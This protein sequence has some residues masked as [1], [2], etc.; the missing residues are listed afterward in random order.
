MPRFFVPPD[1]IGETH[2]RLD[3]ETLAHIRV[4]RLG[5]RE[6][7]TV[8]DG[9][10]AEFRC[11]LAGDQAEIIERVE[12]RAEPKVH[13]T[14]YLGF[15]RGERMD[16]AIQ[17]SVELGAAA[18]RLFPASRCVVQYDEKGLQK[19]L[20][21]WEKIALEAA[22]Q[23]GRGLVPPVT[24]ASTFSGAMTEAKRMDCP[25][26]FY[27][28]E[29]EQSF[30]KTLEQRSAFQ[31]ASL[32]IG[33]EGGFTEEEAVQAKAIGLQVVSLGPRILRAE[34]APAAALA[35]LLFYTGDL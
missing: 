20:P 28:N 32:V 19:K 25:L 29:T 1:A 13:C 6:T 34:T 23:S 3:P 31:T 33:P 27:E 21:R 17:K 30:R 24:A 5:P 9:A 4:L 18:I 35:A 26:F 8:S 15:T 22:K 2:I 12:N 11:T 7:F 14:V 16:Y 10:G